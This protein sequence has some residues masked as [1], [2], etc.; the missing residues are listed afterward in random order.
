MKGAPKGGLLE[1]TDPNCV[2]PADLKKARLGNGGKVKEKGSV[3]TME[4][5]RRSCTQF[6]IGKKAGTVHTPGW[7]DTKKKST[8]PTRNYEEAERLHSEVGMARCAPSNEL[9]KLAL[10]D[11]FWPGEEKTISPTRKSA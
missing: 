5:S 7:V 6:F 11:R 3:Q 9:G 1:G 10:H 4:D 2:G 8:E